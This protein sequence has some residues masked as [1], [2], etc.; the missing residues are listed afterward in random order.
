MF[1]LCL[2]T[3]KFGISL[4]VKDRGAKGKSEF[5]FKRSPTMVKAKVDLK[6]DDLPMNYTT[7]DSMLLNNM[8]RKPWRGAREKD[9]RLLRHIIEGTTNKGDIVL[10]CTASTGEF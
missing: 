5:F 1:F 6:R 4:L 10:D 3:L 9:A 7:E 8:D 2:Q